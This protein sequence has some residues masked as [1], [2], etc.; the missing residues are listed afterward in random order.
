VVFWL[1]WN[2][3]VLAFIIPWYFGNQSVGYADLLVA[4][5]AVIYKIV[6]INWTFCL[7]KLIISRK[8][9]GY[10]IP[11]R[12]TFLEVYIYFFRCNHQCPLI[13]V[14]LFCRNHVKYVKKSWVKNYSSQYLLIVCYYYRCDINELIWFHSIISHL[15]FYFLLEIKLWFYLFPKYFL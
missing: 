5:E 13:W 9:V 7:G 15:I 14:I 1:L 10:A 11:F 4:C 8:S 2:Y 3:F 12:N 6:S